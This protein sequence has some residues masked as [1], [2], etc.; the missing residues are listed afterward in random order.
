MKLTAKEK[1]GGGKVSVG[2]G[3]PGTGD[4]K[5]A[6]FKLVAKEKGGAE[7]SG[8]LRGSC[9]VSLLHEN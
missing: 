7:V 5:H 3:R 6:R 8:A 1:G 4:S 9:G 2:A